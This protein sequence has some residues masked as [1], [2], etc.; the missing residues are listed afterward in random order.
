[1]CVTIFQNCRQ[2]LN[3][4]FLKFSCLSDFSVIF[5]N[6]NEYHFRTREAILMKQKG[7]Y[8]QTL[9]VFIRNILHEV[10]GH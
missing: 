5:E 8:S 4:D 6:E 10:K 1:M 7:M 9:Q 3:F 2:F